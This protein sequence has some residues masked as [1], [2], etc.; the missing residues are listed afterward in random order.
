MCLKQYHE[1]ANY[2]H[3]IHTACSSI[4]IVI[5]AKVQKWEWRE[6][7]GGV[8]RRRCV[9]V[10]VGLYADRMQRNIIDSP[11]VVIHLAMPC[12]G[13][14]DII[15]DYIRRHIAWHGDKQCLCRH[16]HLYNE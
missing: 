5:G 2:N 14:P 10:L 7:G 8:G 13:A 4:H 6:D 1:I 12:H 9:C 15:L 3:N 11:S 16:I